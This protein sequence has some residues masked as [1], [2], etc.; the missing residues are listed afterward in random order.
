VA[1]GEVW[2]PALLYGN[3]GTSRGLG[4][5][6]VSGCLVGRRHVIVYEY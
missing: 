5:L 3:A 6:S 2:H 4:D 1:T